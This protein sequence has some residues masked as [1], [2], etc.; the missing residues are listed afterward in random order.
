MTIVPGFIAAEEE[1]SL[2]KEMERVWRHSKYEYS[3]WDKVTGQN[4]CVMY[5]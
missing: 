3:H 5:M 4:F 2:M 1:S